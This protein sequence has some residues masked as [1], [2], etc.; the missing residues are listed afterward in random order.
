MQPGSELRA[1]D[2]LYAGKAFSDSQVCTHNP[3]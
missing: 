1:I 2:R 3:L